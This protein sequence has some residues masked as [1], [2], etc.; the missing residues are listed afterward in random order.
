MDLIGIECD[1]VNS[2]QLKHSWNVLKLDGSIYFVDV[3][4]DD[5]AACQGLYCEHRNLLVDKISL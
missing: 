2:I 5:P 1:K 3:T 4:W